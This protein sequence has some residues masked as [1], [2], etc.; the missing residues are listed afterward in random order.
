MDIIDFNLLEYIKNNQ[1]SILD[2]KSKLFIEYYYNTELLKYELNAIVTE[3]L[4][5]IK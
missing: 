3:Y 5:T 2:K 4:N 1:Y